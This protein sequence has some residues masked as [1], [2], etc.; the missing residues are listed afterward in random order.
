MRAEDLARVIE[1]A[2]GLSGAPD[3]P[4]N[5]Y[6]RALDPEA[7]PERLA[8]VADDPPAGILGFVVAVLI[9]PQAELETIGVA[10]PVQRQGMGA[11]LLNELLTILEN[12]Q[13]TEVMLEVRESNHP[14]RA[15]YAA[16]RF[17][18]TGRRPAYY[19]DPQED[20]ILLA[21]RIPGSRRGAATAQETE[22]E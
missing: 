21:R 18:E 7:R 11:S 1:I 16:A 3:W 5:A 10:R 2:A 14:A 22:T 4:E 17:E 6:R 9:P 8:L 19:S 12:R 15:L 13:I 20:A